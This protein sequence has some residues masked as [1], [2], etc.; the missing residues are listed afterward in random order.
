MA[1]RNEQAGGVVEDPSDDCRA[2]D[3]AAKNA[4]DS[5]DTLR[6]ANAPQA[7]QDKA[8]KKWSNARESARACNSLLPKFSASRTKFLSEY[9]TLDMTSYPNAQNKA[10]VMCKHLKCCSL[11]D[12]TGDSP[13]LKLPSKAD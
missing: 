6:R 13:A 9:Q 10:A 2:Y 11:P 12:V 3:T 8:G 7:E 5:L 1:A 4:K